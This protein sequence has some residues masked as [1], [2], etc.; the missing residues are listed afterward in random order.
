MQENLRY[1]LGG[2]DSYAAQTFFGTKDRIKLAWG[3][4][5]GDVFCGQMLF[6]AKVTL[7]K[8]TDGIYRLATTPID[9]IEALYTDA[10]MDKAAYALT[11]TL[12]AD[13]APIS[14]N[15]LGLSIQIDP[16]ENRIVLPGGRV[17]PLSYTAQNTYD[18]RLIV[19][20][21]SMEV[22]ADHGKIY[23]VLPV[24][25]DM[26]GTVELPGAVAHRLSHIWEK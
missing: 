3:R 21:I 10:P 4:T 24:Q 12:S 26:T 15:I 7:H 22:F 18:V 11:L 5:G 1:Q 14:G 6:P 20:T 2:A 19:D 25:P 13:T 16:V 9:G 8:D 23:T 17:I